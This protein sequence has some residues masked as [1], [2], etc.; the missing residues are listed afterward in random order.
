MSDAN[1]RRWAS[2][3]AALDANL[4][5]A[6]DALLQESNVTR[7]AKRLGVTQSAMSQ[8]L[9]RLRKQFDDPILVKTGRDMEPS[10]FGLRIK[11]RLH[12]AIFELEAVVR[13]RPAYDPKT[14]TNRFVIATVDYLAFSLAP[15]LGR[16]LEAEAPGVRLAFFALEP[17]SIVGALAEGSVH[18]YVGVRGEAE[19]ALATRALHEETLRVVM[20]PH[21]P[22]ATAPLD[23]DEYA[24]CAHVHV[25]PRREAGSIVER[26]LAEVGRARV[27]AVEVPYFALVPDLLVG[28]TLVATVPS[29]IAARFARTHGLVVRDVPLSLP[30]LEICMAWHPAFAA[31]PS[32][33]WLRELVAR[34]E[35]GSMM[36]A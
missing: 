27:V 7:A 1:A 6:L 12:Q 15:A 36:H 30:R 11:A 31:D 10:A 2:A 29:R 20:D 28:S 25:S 21:H 9:G 13:D 26:G 5:V 23:L 17:A 14:A 8:T 19:R 35:N 4:L 22:L 3:L 32:G 24:A 33:V 18:L 16:A 34:V